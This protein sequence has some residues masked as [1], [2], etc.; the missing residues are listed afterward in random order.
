MHR[1]KLRLRKAMLL[2]KIPWLVGAG[3]ADGA[4]GRGRKQDHVTHFTGPE[5]F[6][7][8]PPK[9]L[10][11]TVDGCIDTKVNRVRLHMK[12]PSAV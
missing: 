11:V 9:L 6:G 5:N 12:T 7:L 1:M 10:N 3:E 8:A 2:L 4:E